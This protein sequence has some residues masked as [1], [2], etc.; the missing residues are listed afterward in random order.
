[1][2]AFKPVPIRILCDIAAKTAPPTLT[3]ANTLALPM[4][5]RGDDIEIDIAIAKL[6]SIVTDVSGIAAVTAQVFA[7]AS[8][9]SGPSMA[10]TVSAAAINQ[11]LNPANWTAGTDQHAAFIFGNTQTALDLGGAPQKSFW[12]RLFATTNDTP[13]K[14][15]TLDEGAIIINDGPLS[16]ISSAPGGGFR[17]FTDPATGRLVAQLLCDDGFYHTLAG[18]TTG[19]VLRLTLS[20]IGY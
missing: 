11:T 19:G 18:Q 12:L 8:D 7:S 10:A 2:A 1:M 3:D 14:I 9:G 17:M 4:F 6:G 5:T 16:V 15:I 20:D 13:A